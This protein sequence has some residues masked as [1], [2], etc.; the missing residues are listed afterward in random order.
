MTAEMDAEH[1]ATMFGGEHSIEG[2]S[3]IR[4]LC[5]CG[6]S[7]DVVTDKP[8]TVRV[9]ADV[10]SDHVRSLPGYVPFYSRP[11]SFDIDEE[12]TVTP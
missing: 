3:Y 10:H 11:L 4:V 5:V 2:T 1:T 6:W 9:I 7:T 12:A 8:V